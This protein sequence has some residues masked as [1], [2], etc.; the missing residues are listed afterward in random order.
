MQSVSNCAATFATEQDNPQNWQSTCRELGNLLQGM[1]RFDE[2][3]TW[4]SLALE[5]QPNFAEIYAQLGSLYAQEKSWDDAIAFF[6]NALKSHPNSVPIHS[7]LAQIYGQMGKR[8]L[9][10][11][12][13]YKAAELKPDLINAQGYYKLGIA[14]EE[15]G[16]IDQA[17][18]C[19]QRACDRENSL[20]PAYYKLAEKRLQQKDL[21]AAKDCLESIIQQDFEQYQAHYE[22]GKILV[23]QEEF[24]AAVEEFRQ[25]IKLEPEFNSAY[26][27]LIGVFMQQKKWDEAISTC[28]AI[29]NLVEEFPWVYSLLGNALRAKGKIDQAVAAYQKFYALKGWNEC[30]TNNYFVPVDQFTHR[31]ALYEEYLLPLAN[32]KNFSALEV[33][34]H[35]GI[36]TCWL[37]DKILTHPSARLTCLDHELNKILKENIAKTGAEDKVKLR[38]KYIAGYL[39][40]FKPQSF[41]L[42]MIQ[43]RR[44]APKSLHKNIVLLWKLVKIGG[45][46]IFGD[47]GW[48]HPQNPDKNPQKVIDMFLNS[49]QGKWELVALPPRSFQLIIKKLAKSDDEE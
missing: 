30:L 40:S 6:E 41:D 34:S 44:K 46:I 2:A 16:K 45:I 15:Q 29:M 14:L 49:M 26:A 37:L 35:F 28:H 10:T 9:E 42:A 13:W 8:E 17:I 7:S 24:D 3:I 47:Y 43:D 5:S 22:L 11:Q 27:S 31:I 36:A 38:E 20:I 32:Q 12:C 39:S 4:H 21:D 19:Y 48:Q 1:G 25:T 33:G 23:N 18:E